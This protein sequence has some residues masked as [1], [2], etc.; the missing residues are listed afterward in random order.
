MYKKIIAFLALILVI[1]SLAGCTGETEN[2]NEIRN[3]YGVEEESK[4]WK[5]SLTYSVTEGEKIWVEGELTYIGDKEP[6]EVDMEFVIYDIEPT[7]FYN[8]NIGDI[9][10]TVESEGKKVIDSKIDISESFTKKHEVEVYKEGI[11]YG[12]IEIKWEKDGEEQV[13]KINIEIDE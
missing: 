9:R 4:N 12:Y 3:E 7:S 1:A 5:L 13:E 11:N 8:E 2:P 10:T 6:E